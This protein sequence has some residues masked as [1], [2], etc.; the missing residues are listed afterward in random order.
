MKEYVFTLYGHRH[1]ARQ[2]TPEGKPLS[3]LY[4]TDT[5]HTPRRKTPEG[6]PLSALYNTDTVHTPRRKTPE[7]KP[8]SALYNTDTVHTPRR[9]TPEGKLL[10]ALYN[11]DAVHAPRRKT[12]DGGYNSTLCKHRPRTT[13]KA[14]YDGM[15]APTPKELT[16]S[17]D[18]AK[19]H[20]CFYRVFLLHISRVRRRIA[21]LSA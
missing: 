20:D 2:K 3:A 14:A 5:V 7:G 10:S 4:N 18:C 13:E 9:K 19:K 16:P 1:A 17:L 21:L 11:T 8:L 12:S 15:A 6:K